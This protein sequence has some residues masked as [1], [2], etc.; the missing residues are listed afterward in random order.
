L[1][2]VGIK[3]TALNH[4]TVDDAMEDGAVVV[5]A[6]YV[7]FKVGGGNR[8]LVAEQFQNDFAKV[9]GQFDHG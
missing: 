4:E 9:G 5:A 1:L 2:H 7:F 8:G 6:L 3:A